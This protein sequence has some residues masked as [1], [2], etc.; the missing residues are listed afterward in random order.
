M[1][2]AE[3]R[4]LRALRDALR[5]NTAAVNRLAT[6]AEAQVQILLQVRKVE[7][8]SAMVGAFVQS[9]SAAALRKLARLG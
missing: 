3:L 1:N 5:D 2:D 9:V 6:A 4:E 7:G 8:A